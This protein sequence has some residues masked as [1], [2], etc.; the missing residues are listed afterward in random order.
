MSTLKLRR[1]RSTLAAGLATL[2][3]VLGAA[4]PAQAVEKTKYIALGDSYAAGQGAG[5]YL[6]DCYRSENTYAE[7]A[8]E[9]KAVKLIRN[10]ACSGKTTQEVANTQLRQLNKSTE[11]VTITAGGNNLRVGDLF[12][13]CGAALLAPAAAPLCDAAIAFATAEI[14][15]GRLA[16]DVASLIQRVRTA[17][18][19][20][21]IVVTGYPY[22]YDPVVPDPAD[23]LSLFIH[24]ATFLVDGLNGSI[25]T[26]AQGPR[27][28]YVDVKAAFAGHG[29]NSAIPWIN[30]NLAA[31]T[32][33]DNF[34]PNA[35]GYKAYYAAL[36][37]AGAYQTP[38]RDTHS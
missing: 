2:A 38:R 20:A 8:A 33:A 3:M 7:L 18:P 16:G 19:N 5:P 22:L 12:R 13:Y 11:L 30:L 24:R 28:E 1:R 37:G 9:A 17:A 29:I 26:A 4:V 25:I 31:P 14:Q 32:N 21:K 15:S 35:A 36:K 34:H 23:P 10:A 6:D 27:V